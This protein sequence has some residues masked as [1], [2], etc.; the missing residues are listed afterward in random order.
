VDLQ[1]KGKRAFVS[2]SSSG[3]GK[4]IALMLAGEGCD[5][6]VHGRDKARTE[7]TAHAVEALGV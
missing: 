6:G 5:I 3:I 7:E 4:A 2:G 1:L